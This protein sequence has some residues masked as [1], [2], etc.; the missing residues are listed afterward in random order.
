MAQ[1][2]GVRAKVLRNDEN[3]GLGGSHKVAFDYALTH[4]FDRVAV[5]HGDDQGL[6]DDLVTALERG[7][8][9]PVDALLGARFQPGATLEGYSR[10]RTVGNRVLNR[11]F[12]LVVGRRLYD[13]GSGLNLYR[14]EPLRDRFWHT[15][16]DDLTFNYCL[17]LAQ[18]HLGH[19][20]AFFPIR[21]REEDQVSNVR[22]VSQARR[23]FGLLA[24]FVRDP[25]RFVTAEHRTVPRAAYTATVIADNG[26]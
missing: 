26:A 4:G 24:R 6:F 19:R 9:H 25:G 3:Y 23:V 12:S 21:W 2:T 15:F 14:V 16:P 22:L 5:L 20:L 1:I 10:L 18:L 8:H 17:I 11:L 13:L 7:D